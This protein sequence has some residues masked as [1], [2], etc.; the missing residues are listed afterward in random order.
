MNKELINNTLV[1]T[2]DHDDDIEMKSAIQDLGILVDFELKY[3]DL[4]TTQKTNN[5]R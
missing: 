2:P 1:F 4:S 3:K 5:L